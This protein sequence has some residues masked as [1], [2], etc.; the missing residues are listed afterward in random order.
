MEF[1]PE[2]RLEG[3]KKKKSQRKKPPNRKPWKALQR[4][5]V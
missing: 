3:R 5:H 1:T 4:F 2:I